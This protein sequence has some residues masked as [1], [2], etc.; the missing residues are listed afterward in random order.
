MS[1][2]RLPGKMLKMLGNMTIIDRVYSNLK[3]TE[4]VSKIIVAT[5]EDETDLP[6]VNH[7][8]KNKITCFRGSLQDV[9]SRFLHISQAENEAAFV[10][11]SGDSPIIDPKLVG[12][13]I[14]KFEEG[15]FDL[16]TNVHERTYPKG[17]SVEVFSSK[18]FNKSYQLFKTPDHFEHVSSYYYENADAFN[19]K[20]IRSGG[21]YNDINLSIDTPE[22]Y[23]RLE[24]LAVEYGESLY[25]WRD[26]ANKY[27]EL[28]LNA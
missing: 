11:I 7:C 13:L 10:R 16:V 2:K 19:I 12:Q 20:N 28:F 3:K 21:N 8:Y 14:R 23:K 9:A 4:G 1:S 22:D 26:S 6:L 24:L 25:N 27:S 18:I 15:C 5:S 17:Q